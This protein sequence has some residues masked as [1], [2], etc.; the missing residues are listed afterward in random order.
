F[1]QL[2]PAARRGIV[3]SMKAIVASRQHGFKSLCHGSSRREEAHFSSGE[4]ISAS[5]RRLPQMLESAR[6]DRNSLIETHPPGE[7]S[8]SNQC[9]QKKGKH[10][11]KT[12][13]V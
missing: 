10:V 13:I 11:M 4:K 1:Y 3:L 6:L 7:L 2:A 8:S 9:H 12:Q 5:S